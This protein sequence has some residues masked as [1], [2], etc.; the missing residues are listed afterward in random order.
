MSTS[1]V[2][3]QKQLEEFEYVYWDVCETISTNLLEYSGYNTPTY[4]LW[5]YDD[6]YFSTRIKFNSYK[7]Y[8]KK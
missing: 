5:I 3:S 6:W 8:Y 2:K 7:I 1:S 4:F